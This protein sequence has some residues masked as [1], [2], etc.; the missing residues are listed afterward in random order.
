[1]VRENQQQNFG[2]IPLQ[3]SQIFLPD[4]QFNEGIEIKLIY[5][6]DIQQFIDGSSHGIILFTFGSVVKA[7]SLTLKQR[8]SFISAFASIP[9][10]VIWKYEDQIENLP[11]NVMLSE[12]LPQRDILGT[13][14]WLHFVEHPTH[15]T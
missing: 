6:Q 13:R 1:M 10:R 7:S 11:A 8:E 15:N 3:I 14:C 2:F 12:W 4:E 9:Q 5:L